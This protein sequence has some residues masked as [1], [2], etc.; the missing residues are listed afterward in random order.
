VIALFAFQIL[1]ALRTTAFASGCTSRASFLPFIVKHRFANP[2]QLVV[3][4]YPAV[5]IT[6]IDHIVIMSG[7]GFRPPFCR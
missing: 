3:F 7:C 4:A 2:V 5:I 1:V 6:L